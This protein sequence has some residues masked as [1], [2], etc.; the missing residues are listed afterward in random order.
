METGVF[1]SAFVHKTCKKKQNHAIF[2][3]TIIFY[4]LRKWLIFNYLCCMLY[5]WFDSR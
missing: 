5:F 2:Y 4:K 1:L 3:H